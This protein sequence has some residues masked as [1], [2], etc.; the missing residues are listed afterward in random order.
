MPNE[1]LSPLSRL[2]RLD[3]T[4]N[5]LS[6]LPESFGSS[7]SSL[8][9]LLV[10]HNS[11][12]SLPN[13]LPVSLTT[14]H[15]NNNQISDLTPLVALKSLVNAQLQENDIASLPNELGQLAHLQTLRLDFNALSTL[16]ISLAQAPALKVLTLNG[17][18]FESMPVCLSSSELVNGLEVL[19]VGLL[20]DDDASPNELLDKA[21][22]TYLRSHSTPAATLIASYGKS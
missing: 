17:N 7:S 15:A 12:I 4:K 19:I 16:P 11:L 21:P 3:L 6:T 5:K 14:L 22:L 1:F 13:A 2:Q 9:T 8:K 20:H 10:G 18:A